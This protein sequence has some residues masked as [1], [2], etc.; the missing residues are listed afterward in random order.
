VASI[1][2]HPEEESKNEKRQKSAD[3][4]VKKFIFSKHY[5]SPACAGIE[6]Q[7]RLGFLSFTPPSLANMTPAAASATPSAII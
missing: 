6:F 1:K 3:Y 4:C 2:A 5:V 7:D